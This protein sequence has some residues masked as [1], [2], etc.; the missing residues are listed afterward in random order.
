MII[1]K[2]HNSLLIGTNPGKVM[3][4]SDTAGLVGSCF[5]K[6]VNPSN[7]KGG[8]RAS[9]ISPYNP[10]MFD[11]DDFAP[12]SLT[13]RPLPD[14]LSTDTSPVP[15][16]ASAPVPAPAPAQPRHFGGSRK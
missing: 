10:G 6:A 1:V 9:G 16:P 8:F 11:D 12:A 5:D 13:D 7:I 4:I 2:R 14:S 3:A 15:S